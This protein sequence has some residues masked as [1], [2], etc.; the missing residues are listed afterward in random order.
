MPPARLGNRQF[1]IALLWHSGGRT[2]GEVGPADRTS[3]AQ[4][5]REIIKQP[6]PDGRQARLRRRSAGL[7]FSPAGR[8]SGAD[9]AG[10]NTRSASSGHA[11]ADLATNA[12]RSDQARALP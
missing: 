12:L 8:L 11:G 2:E 3:Q 6:A 1:R 5:V 7:A 4:G 9:A 10:T